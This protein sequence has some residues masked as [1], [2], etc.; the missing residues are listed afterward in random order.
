MICD[1]EEILKDADEDENGYIDIK[2]FQ[3]LVSTFTERMNEKEFG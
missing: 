3:K 1:I 2:E